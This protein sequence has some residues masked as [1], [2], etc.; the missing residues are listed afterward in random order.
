MEKPEATPHKSAR[1]RE[2]IVQVPK[3]ALRSDTETI[4]IQMELLRQ[5]PDMPI[6]SNMNEVTEWLDKVYR[7]YLQ[8]VRHEVPK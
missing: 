2:T 7:P 4:N 6:L 5:A 8:A 1:V 3:P